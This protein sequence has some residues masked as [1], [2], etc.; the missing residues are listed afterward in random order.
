MA[1]V[2]MYLLEEN[3]WDECSFV[4][5]PH[6]SQNCISRVH[7]FKTCNDLKLFVVL[8][9]NSRELEL[10]LELENSLLD[11]IAHSKLQ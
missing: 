1:Q 9:V 5:S 8:I 3:T 6:R 2:V 11:K 10:E 4:H 7:R